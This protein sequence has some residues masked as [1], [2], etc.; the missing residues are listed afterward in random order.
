MY[1]DPLTGKRRMT[2]YHLSEKDALDRYGPDAEK[3]E[4]TRFEPRDLGRTSDFM[5]GKG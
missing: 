1:T 3:V 4:W 2:R 5:K